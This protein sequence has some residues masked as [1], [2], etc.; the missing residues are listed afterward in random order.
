V[1]SSLELHTIPT[2]SN[3]KGVGGS[4]IAVQVTIYCVLEFNGAWNIRVAKRTFCRPAST[5]SCFRRSERAGFTDDICAILQYIYVRHRCVFFRVHQDVAVLLCTKCVS[6]R[7][8][9]TNEVCYHTA[10]HGQIISMLVRI[11][12]VHSK[13]GANVRTI[14]SWYPRARVWIIMHSARHNGLSDSYLFP[15]YPAQ[16]QAGYPSD[17]NCF[18]KRI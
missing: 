2:D 15:E 10:V 18:V 9:M 12:A 3:W 5:S 17:T 7:Q 1:H 4:Y 11:V 16:D 13:R 14:I 8:F 6:I